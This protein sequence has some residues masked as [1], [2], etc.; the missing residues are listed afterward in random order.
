LAQATLS[1]DVYAE[2]DEVGVHV[3]IHES[4]AHKAPAVTLVK[5][6]IMQY[7]SVGKKGRPML[8]PPIEMKLDRVKQVCAAWLHA[9]WA[10]LGLFALPSHARDYQIP[11]STPP[12]LSQ[13]TSVGLSQF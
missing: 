13:K 7:M 12:S 9:S 5:A 1:R 10:Q 2:G 11:P 6:K 3:T 8:R 4:G